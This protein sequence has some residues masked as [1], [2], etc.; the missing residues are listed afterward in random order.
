[1]KHAE[2]LAER[3][4]DPRHVANA[5]GDGVCVDG[6]VR[7]GKRLCVAFNE[8]YTVVEMLCRGA[9]A[10]DAKHVRIDVADRGAES[11]A[12]RISR[13][14]SD[15]AGPAGDVEQCEARIALGRVDRVDH[16]F[17]PD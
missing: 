7:K 5:E 1:P 9:F 11:V 15:V 8:G 4:V 17:L 12:R 14:E 16:D 10:P 6:A 13:A 2:G 3:N